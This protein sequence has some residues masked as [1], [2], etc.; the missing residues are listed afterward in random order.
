MDVQVWMQAAEGFDSRGN[1]GQCVFHSGGNAQ[2]AFELG[3]LRTRL[4]HRQPC[5]F[6]HACAAQVETLAGIGERQLPGVTG[7]QGD[8]QLRFQALEVEADHGAGLAQ[9]VGGSGKRAG[10]DHGL[11]SV[12]SVQ[13]DH[14]RRP[15]L[16]KYF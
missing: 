3:M 16:S 9:Q 5:F 4:F 8:A 10:L 7:Q 1:H 14:R 2:R 12:E 15:P 6:E 11:E 13:A